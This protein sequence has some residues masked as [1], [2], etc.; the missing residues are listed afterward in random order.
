MAAHF[1][2]IHPIYTCFLVK[3]A[4]KKRPFNMKYAAVFRTVTIQGSE[5]AAVVARLALQGR[6]TCSINIFMGILFAK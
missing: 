3:K 6:K 1:S 5:L 2:Q 4:L